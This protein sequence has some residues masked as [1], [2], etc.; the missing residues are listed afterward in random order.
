MFL[1]LMGL[2]TAIIILMAFTPLGYIRTGGL[3]IT[4][5]VV[6]VAAG[7]VLLS[8]LGSQMWDGAKGVL[9]GSLGGAW[10][11]LVFG[12]TSLIQCF[13]GDPFG[14]MLLSIN[15][16]GTVVT[17]IVARLLTGFLTGLIFAALTKMNVKYYTEL[18]KDNGE[19]FFAGNAKRKVARTTAITLSNL[20]CPLLNTVFFMS[21]LVLFFYNTEYI[22]GFVTAL[23]AANPFNFVLLFVGVNGAIEAFTCFIIGA[24]VTKALDVAVKR[25]G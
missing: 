15:P 2:F 10:L 16:F 5:I 18:Y 12:A 4:L 1:T 19:V 3:S 17:C 24:A 11:G 25:I 6:P 23:G 22:Q 9:L 20:C 13:T 21:S 14:A 7:A 8:S